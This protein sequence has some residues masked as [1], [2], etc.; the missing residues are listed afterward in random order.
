MLVSLYLFLLDSYVLLFKAIFTLQPSIFFRRTD[1][2]IYFFLWMIPLPW[3]SNLMVLNGS[4]FSHFKHPMTLMQNPM[5]SQNPY[6]LN[7]KF[8]LIQVSCD[9]SLWATIG[10]QDVERL[11]SASTCYNTLK[12]LLVQTPKVRSNNIKYLL[13]NLGLCLPFSY[14][15]EWLQLPTYKRA[16]TLRAKILYAIN[17]NTG[18]ELS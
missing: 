8:D 9:A 14:F 6:W 16:S 7:L 11:P 18:F 15:L 13:S 12:V 2:Y 17:S 3:L 1:M 4:F 10:G 5:G